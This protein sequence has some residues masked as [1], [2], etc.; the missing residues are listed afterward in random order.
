MKLY[1]TQFEQIIETKIK[2]NLKVIYNLK[3]QNVK[4][5]YIA[6]ALGISVKDFQ[7]ALEVNE[8]VKEIYEDAM[9]ILVSNLRDIVFSRALGTDGKTDKDGNLLG[10][11]AELAFKILGKLDNTFAN[12][13]EVKETLTI[14]HVIREIAERKQAQ[15]EVKE[16]VIA[17]NVAKGIEVMEDADLYM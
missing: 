1:E 15:L 8:D 14:E 7:K 12:K 6:Q 2:P 16:T 5:K 13:V 4:D 9:M 3:I 11:D 10:P 17:K